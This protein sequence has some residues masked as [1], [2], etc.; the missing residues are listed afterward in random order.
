MKYLFL[1]LTLSSLS[2]CA[3][4]AHMGQAL[5]KGMQQN[6]RYGYQQ[7][8]RQQVCTTSPNGFGGFRTVCN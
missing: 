8:Q 2:G 5:G 6:A 4:M 7:P 1:L 3:G